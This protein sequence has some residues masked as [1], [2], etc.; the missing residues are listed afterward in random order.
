MGR[1]KL[2]INPPV[3]V[4]KNT[5]KCTFLCPKELEVLFNE[6]TL[7]VEYSREIDRIPKSLLI[8]PLLSNI[9]PIAW[10]SDVDIHVQE[11]DKN[12]L[13]SSKKIRSCLK[14][15]YPHLSFKGDIYANTLIENVDYCHQKSGSLFS[16]GVDSLTTYI[17]K[18]KEQPALITIWGSDISVRNDR[19]WNKVRN[20]NV[21]FGIKNKITNL[22]LKSN[23]RSMLNYSKIDN[24]FSINWWAKI[25][26]GYALLGLCAPLSYSEGLQTIYIPSSHSS[27]TPDVTWGSHPLIDNH[28]KWGQT[29][30]I[31]EGY[32]LT[33]QDKLEVIAE[34]IKKVDSSLQVRVCWQS[35]SERNCG[36]CEK[37]SRTIIGLMVEGIDPNRQGFQINHQIFDHIKINLLQDKWKL[38]KKDIYFWEDIRKNAS[39]QEKNISPEGKRFFAWLQ[40]FEFNKLKASE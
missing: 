11:I 38:S 2:I 19:A 12:F 27:K 10:A 23:F 22:F 34:Y 7:W 29:S 16:G 13:Q 37:C 40:K 1:K 15:F 20:N 31:H 5:I 35:G 26:H 17:R 25:Q 24:Q 9:L 36:K 6:T 18:R 3:I 14:K 39:L 4:N 8:I 32:E 30:V 33:R 28:V 21:K